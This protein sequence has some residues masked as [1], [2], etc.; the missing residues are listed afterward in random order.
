MRFVVK[1]AGTSIESF[2]E[3]K[4]TELDIGLLIKDSQRN[5]FYRTTVTVKNEQLIPALDNKHP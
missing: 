4:I 1:H 3:G 2:K 5:V